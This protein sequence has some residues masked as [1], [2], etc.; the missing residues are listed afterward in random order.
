[1][2]TIIISSALL[3]AACLI[4]CRCSSLWPRQGVQKRGRQLAM[5]R[6]VTQR[7]AECLLAVWQ[8]H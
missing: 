3:L 8:L 6:T 4:H 1:R 7:R 5:P 2:E